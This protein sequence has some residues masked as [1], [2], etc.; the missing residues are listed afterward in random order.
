[1]QKIDNHV[2]GGGDIHDIANQNLVPSKKKG[3]AAGQ[4]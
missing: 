4:Q 3:E 1:M 2:L